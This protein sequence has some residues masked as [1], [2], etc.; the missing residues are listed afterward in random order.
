MVQCLSFTKF[1]AELF[2]DAI[3][4]LQTASPCGKEGIN[5]KGEIKPPTPLIPPFKCPTVVSVPAGQDW[6]ALDNKLNNFDANSLGI[7]KLAGVPVPNMSIAYGAG[8]NNIAQPGQMPFTKAANGSILPEYGT[9]D[10]DGLASIAPSKNERELKAVIDKKFSELLKK[11]LQKKMQGMMVSDCNELQ[12]LKDSDKKFWEEKKRKAD[13]EMKKRK[14]EYLKQLSEE[15][16]KPWEDRINERKT[17]QL[18]EEIQ[19]MFGEIKGFNNPQPSL[20][21]S[22][23]SPNTFRQQPGLFK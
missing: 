16:D 9:E 17:K 7:K 4:M 13:E 21:S 20:N 1:Y 14:D 11:I 19:K 2:R 5:S 15:F 18:S 10:Y 6:H 3:A 23:Q 8:G 12:S 22:V